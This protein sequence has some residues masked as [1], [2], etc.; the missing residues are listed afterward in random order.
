ML[1]KILAC[2]I[3]TSAFLAVTGN[4]LAAS[5]AAG[6]LNVGPH[7]IGGT[8]TGPTGPE[9]GVWVIA[10]TSDLG[11]HLVKVVVTDDQGRFMV[12]DLPDAKYKL[13]SRGYGVLD[14]KPIEATPGKVLNLAVSATQSPV[15][16][17]QVYPASYWF[18]L[19]QVPAANE[20][21]GTGPTGNGIS[22]AF[23]LQEH[24]IA[25]MVE[26]C[27]FCHQLGTYR[28]RTLPDTGNALKAWDQRVSVARSPDD[29]FFEGDPNYHGRHYGERMSNLMTQFGRQRGL[30]MF[31][32]WTTRISKGQVPPAPP[33]PV[34]IERNLV[35]TMWD[36]GDGRFMHDSSSSD[37]RNPTVNAGGPIYGYGTFSGL[38]VALDP[39]TG[40]QQQIKLTDKKGDYFRSAMDHTGTLDSKGRVWTTTIGSIDVQP[41]VE[42]QERGDNPDWCTNP[43]NK[44]AKFFPRPSKA[45]RLTI[46]F[47]PK[48]KRNE[49]LPTCFGTHH[50][51]FDKNERLYFSGDLEVVGWIDVPVW[52]KTKDLAKATGWCPMVLDTNGDGKIT[53]D[54]TQ[55][56]VWLDGAGGGGEGSFGRPAEKGGGFD[57]SKD[58]RIT[59]FNYGMAVSPKDQSYWA[60]K[61]SPYF[62]SGIV[63]VQPG[64]NPPET[65][66]TEYYEPP[67]VNGMNVAYN[68]RGVDIDADGIAWVAFG[69][70]A[71]GKFDRSKCKTLN[72]PTA[73]GQQCPE[74]WEIIPTAG[75]K[76]QG[77]DIGSDWFYLTFVDRYNTFGLGSGVPIFPNSTGDELLAYLP[78][79]KRFV[80]LRV[81]Y[82]LGF[83]ARGVDGRIDNAKAGWKGRGLWATNNIVALWHQE[84]GEGSNLYAAHFQMR[85]NPLAD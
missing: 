80:H 25:H 3:T 44:F 74:G 53:P 10:E 73:T 57:P 4:A 52:D 49:L 46:V 7:S 54:R 34:G 8:V 28:T 23:K 21:P 64:F 9:A 39:T 55:W 14:S 35:V 72:G 1:L 32:D 29:I 30:E 12:P 26:N 61:Y 77:T 37:K 5:K 83:Y 82:P 51:N 71:I 79:E 42:R 13:W 60:A 19:M 65:C 24:W 2:L 47:D 36:M 63:R 75:P 68:A 31:A 48:T 78:K 15:E 69:T 43:D 27:Q 40:K 17:A 22:P 62:P 38:I 81:P 66:T 41:E 76:L 56:N 45:A 6:P 84:G 67:K 58:T 50:L 70:G 16:L 59:G 18:S 11:N 33:R 85:P 20:F